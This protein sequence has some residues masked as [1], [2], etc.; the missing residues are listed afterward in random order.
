MIRKSPGE[1]VKKHR[2]EGMKGGRGD[3]SKKG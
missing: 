2:V 1:E 3:R